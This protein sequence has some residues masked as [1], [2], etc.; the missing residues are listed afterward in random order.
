[1][2]V[3]LAFIS[4]TMAVHLNFAQELSQR[5]RSLRNAPWSRAMIQIARGRMVTPYN[6]GPPVYDS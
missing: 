2:P 4:E 1:M 6:V 5:F 3:Y